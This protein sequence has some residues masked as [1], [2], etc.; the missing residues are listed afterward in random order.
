VLVIKAEGVEVPVERL[1]QLVDARL[2]AEP[3]F[4]EEGPETRVA[5]L[6]HIVRGGRPTAMDRILGSRLAHVAVDALLA[7]KSRVMA[8]WGPWL[9]KEPPG[10]ERAA[11]DPHCWLVPLDAVLEETERLLDGRADRTQWRKQLF[12]SM[13]DVLAS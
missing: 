10:A 13:A 12:E 1:K 4:A 2:R 7:G 3:E 9:G 11:A 5:V 6:G 8:G